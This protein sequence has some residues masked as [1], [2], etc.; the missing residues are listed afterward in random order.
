VQLLH[1]TLKERRGRRRLLWQFLLQPF[2]DGIADR[3][4]GDAI[5]FLVIH[6]RFRFA[7]ISTR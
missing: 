7:F 6:D 3:S 4:A 2:A 5:D 1:E